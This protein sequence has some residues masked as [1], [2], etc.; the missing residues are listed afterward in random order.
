MPFVLDASMTM[1]WCFEDEKTQETEAILRELAFTHAEVPALWPYEVTNPL[2]SSVRRGRMSYTQA[3]NFLQRLGRL[4]IRI[5]DQN[6]PYTGL[7]LL[8]FISQYGLTAYDAAY[9]ELAKRKRLPL[10]TL[11][12]HLVAAAPLEGVF[13]LG[14]KP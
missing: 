8:P 9:L 11:D 10:A 14:Q 3:E 5:D 12:K 4:A 7:K 13:L 1:S 2:A 6:D